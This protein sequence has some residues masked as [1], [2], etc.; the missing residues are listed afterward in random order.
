M[1]SWC[2]TMALQSMPPMLSFSGECLLCLRAWNPAGLA[3]RAIS[4]TPPFAFEF[5]NILLDA[6]CLAGLYVISFSG[7]EPLAPLTWP[8]GIACVAGTSCRPQP[9]CACSMVDVNGLSSDSSRRV[10]VVLVRVL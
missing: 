3:H 10:V 6:C 8:L 2:S 7:M 4:S 5:L 1:P 9:A